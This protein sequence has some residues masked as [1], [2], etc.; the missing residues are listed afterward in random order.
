MFPGV[1]AQS[2]DHHLKPYGDSLIFSSYV[3]FIEQAGALV[4][5]VRYDVLYIHKHVLYIKLNRLE[6][7]FTINDKLYSSFLQEIKLYFIKF[8]VLLSM[9]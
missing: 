1:L 8:Y 3:K 4:I 7:L 6:S 5:P 2:V 9:C